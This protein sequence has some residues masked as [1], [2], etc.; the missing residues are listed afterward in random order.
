MPK[1][2]SAWIYFT[3]TY[4]LKKDFTNFIKDYEPKLETYYI[5]WTTRFPLHSSKTI[6][7]SCYMVT[8]IIYFHTVFVYY[9]ILFTTAP[10]FVTY[11][12]LKQ[13][14]SSSH[15][16]VHTNTLLVL[17]NT[18]CDKIGKYLQNKNQRDNYVTHLE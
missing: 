13:H 11:T 6:I 17:F 3:D 9:Y 8:H 5:K 16:I 10:N 12:L 15:F 14:I 4:F 1:K 2:T 7:N 18:F